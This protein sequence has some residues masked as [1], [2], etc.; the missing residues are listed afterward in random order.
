MDTDNSIIHSPVRM[1]S[2]FPSVTSLRLP[3]FAETGS[4]VK[5]IPRNRQHIQ[6]RRLG[7]RVKENI[8]EPEPQLASKHAMSDTVSLP[9]SALTSESGGCFGAEQDVRLSLKMLIK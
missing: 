7:R 8:V 2:Q 9:P 5:Y 6:E 1:S 4:D 3:G